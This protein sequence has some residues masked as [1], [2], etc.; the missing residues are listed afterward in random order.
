MVIFMRY[1]FVRFPDGKAKALTLSYDDGFIPD[2]KLIEMLNR[3]NI[4]TTLNISSGFM[5]QQRGQGWHLTAEELGKL[6]ESGGHEIAVHGA[7]HIAPCKASAVNGIADIL[8][9]RRDLERALGKIIRGMAYPD[10]GIRETT[11]I[12]KEEIKKYLK[13]LGIVYSRTLGKDNDSFALP[14]DWLEWVPTAHHNN[15]LL[16]TYLDKFLETDPQKNYIA[17]QNSLLFY[18]WGHSFEYENDKNWDLLE[19]FCKKAGN[20]D[21][22]WYATNIEIYDYVEAFRSLQFSVDSDLI[23]NPTLYTVWFT[24]DSEL[25]SIKPGETLKIS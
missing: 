10:T 22:I 21:D 1:C 25:F 4:K 6:A 17:K 19:E 3:Y 18:L 23:Y 12:R 8:D 9:C 7:H 24:M 16:M 5:E 20:R 11:D 14:E 13:S 2:R 15:P